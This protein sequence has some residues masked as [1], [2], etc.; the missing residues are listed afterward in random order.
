MGQL[1]FSLR[2]Q[3]GCYDHNRSNPPDR[4][5]EAENWVDGRRQATLHGYFFIKKSEMKELQKMKFPSPK[6]HV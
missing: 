1:F 2:C 4:D 3:P 6:G 5:M